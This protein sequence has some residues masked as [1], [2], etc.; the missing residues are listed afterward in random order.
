[1]GRVLGR[2]SRTLDGSGGV[3]AIAFSCR[4]LSRHLQSSGSCNTDVPPRV[5]SLR[6]GVWNNI[7]DVLFPPAGTMTPVRT[8]H[9]LA[10]QPYAVPLI[11]PDLRLEEAIQQVAEALQHLQN[12]S[13]DIF[14]RWELLR[15][16]VLGSRPCPRQHLC[17]HRKASSGT[18]F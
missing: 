9:S 2:V 17:S 16:T 8:Q 13:A 15:V 14:S 1:M 5:F 4:L 7:P 10:G 12:I 18:A 11:Q 3:P 6:E